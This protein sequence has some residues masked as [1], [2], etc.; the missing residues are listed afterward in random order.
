MQSYFVRYQRMGGDRLEADS[1][2]FVSVLV[3]ILILG[4]LSGRVGMR[5]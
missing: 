3:V 4:V 5:M 1:G 2:C